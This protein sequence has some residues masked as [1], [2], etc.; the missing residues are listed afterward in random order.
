MF[1]QS[2]ILNPLFWIAMGLLYA[3]IIASARI[4]A[5]DLGLKMSFLKW[6]HIVIWFIFI[7]LTIA[8]GFTLYGEDELQAGNYLLGIFGTIGVIWGV[9]LW[10]ILQKGRDKN[11]G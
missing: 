11:V 4:W 10:R 6:L 7:T 9:G 1:P 5:K 8:A 2:T 3:V